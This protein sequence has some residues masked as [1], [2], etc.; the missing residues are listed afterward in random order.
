MK[1]GRS[2]QNELK[3]GFLSINFTKE[4]SIEAA[5]FIKQTIC[6]IFY[7]LVDEYTFLLKNYPNT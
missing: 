6:K 4:K 2:E 5:Y 3:I 7:R 1:I